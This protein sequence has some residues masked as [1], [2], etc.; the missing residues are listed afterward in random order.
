MR[1]VVATF[2]VVLA[3]A[4]VA[5]A[6]D[7]RDLS[8]EA[9][10]RYAKALKDAVTL[11]Q[12]RRFDDARAALDKLIAERPHEPQARFLL[13]VVET[14][15]G[16]DDAAIQ[17]FTE[18][19]QQFPE[20]PEPH[21]NLAVLYAKRGNIDGARVEL[22]TALKAA[23]DWAVAHENLGDLHVRSAAEHYERA[24]KLDNLNKSAAAKLALARNLVA[25]SSASAAPAANSASTPK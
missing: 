2:F 4:V 22:E 18:L 8:D 16:N 10:T 7:G 1:R 9:R 20:L 14:E 13:G 15:S 17:T 23:P 3:F 12:Q 6:Q 25:T 11:V 5:H 24:A 19:V 21:N